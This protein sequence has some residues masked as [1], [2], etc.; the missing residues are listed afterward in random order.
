MGG[1][2]RGGLLALHDSQDHFPFGLKP[3]ILKSHKWWGFLLIS[4]SRSLE[5]EA[6][7]DRTKGPHTPFL[8]TC[9]TPTQLRQSQQTDGHHTTRGYALRFQSTIPNR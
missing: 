5:L 8:N 3:Q 7:Q 6:L 2:R 9:V 1:C 4:I